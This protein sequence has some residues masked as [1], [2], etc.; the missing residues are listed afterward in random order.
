MGVKKVGKFNFEGVKRK[1]PAIKRKV[2]TLMAVN[3]EKFFSDNFDRQGFLDRSL[4]RWRPS[5]K[6]RGKTLVNTGSLRRSIAPVSVSFRQIRIETVG[7]PYAAVH[8]DGGRAGRGR[9]TEIPKRKFM[10]NSDSLHKENIKII[11]KEFD[12]IV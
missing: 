6:D 1:L 4:E 7:I 10:G 12:K 2:A 8:N 5:R 11:T 9:K 3:T